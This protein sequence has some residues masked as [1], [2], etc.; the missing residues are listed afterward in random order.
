MLRKA[1]PLYPRH[2]THR[3][4]AQLSKLHLSKMLL[5]AAN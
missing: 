2:Y 3:N 1:K 4:A 5:S